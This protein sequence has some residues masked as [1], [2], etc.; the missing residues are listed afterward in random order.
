MCI[1]V[2]QILKN[3]KSK[4]AGSNFVEDWNNIPIELYI[5]KGISFGKETVQGIRI[6]DKPPTPLTLKDINLI[7]GKV[8]IITSQDSLNKFYADLTTKEKTNKDVI[9]ILKEKQTDLKQV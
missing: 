5:Q 1:R 3:E 6:K 2:K 7:K 9:D 8:S 4:F